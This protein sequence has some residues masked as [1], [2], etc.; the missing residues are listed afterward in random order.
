MS[1]YLR[2]SDIRLGFSN[3]K[4]IVWLK[5]FNEPHQTDTMNKVEKDR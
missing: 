5:D 4:R 1:N 2:N 3:F